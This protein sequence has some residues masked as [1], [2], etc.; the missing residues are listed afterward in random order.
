MVAGQ[1]AMGF[2]PRA[3]A[4]RSRPHRP[5]AGGRLQ[6]FPRHREGRDQAGHQR[7]LHLRAGRQPAGRPGAGPDQFLG[8]LRRHGRLQPGRRRR[9]GAVQLDGRRRSR[10]R[11]LGHG[12]RPLGRMGVASLHQR[13]GARELFQALLDPLPQR[14]TAGGAAGADDAALRH[15]GRA[16]RR[17]GRQ[18][19]SRDAALVR[20]QGQ[21][22]EGHRL[23]PPLQ[24]FR[25]CRQRG[26]CGAPARRRHRDRQLRQIRSVGRGR[27][28]LPQPADDQSHAEEGPHRADADAQRIRPADRRLHHR[29]WGDSPATRDS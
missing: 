13:Q 16:E 18:L 23:I 3:A 12:C 4:A 6:A 7:S 22:A 29:Q 14:G 10:L 27:G 5:L 11:R 8:R 24:R 15:H 28:G 26:A 20:P 2:R 9:P 25:A 19:G 1:H 21:R 17:H